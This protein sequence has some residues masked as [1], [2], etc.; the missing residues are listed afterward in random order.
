MVQVKKNRRLLRPLPTI[1]GLI[2]IVAITVGILELTNTIS[3]FHVGKSP[4]HT[5]HITAGSN[6]AGGT[7]QNSQKGETQTTYPVVNSTN[8]AQPGD[9]KSSIGGGGGTVPDLLIPSGDFVSAHHISLDTAITSVCNTSPGANCVI[10]FS[11]NGDTKSL[12]T[13]VAD[14]GGSA[15]W[16]DWTP[17]G[18]GLAAGSWQVQAIASLGGQTKTA[19]DAMKLV[20]SQ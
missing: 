17:S 7:S 14:R 2:A 16:N 15:Y 12:P 5:E 3:L 11:A 13:E 6:I 20:I 10:T 19:L 4:A 8:T 1:V 18:I 9:N